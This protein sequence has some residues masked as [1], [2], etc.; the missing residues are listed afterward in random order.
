MIMRCVDCNTLAAKI[1]YCLQTQINAAATQTQKN[2]DEALG[3]EERQMA[4]DGYRPV[5]QLPAKSFDDLAVRASKGLCVCTTVEI[6]QQ[7][8][9]CGGK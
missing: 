3:V 5:E 8:C 1:D 4:E 6:M 9:T 7:G 2:I